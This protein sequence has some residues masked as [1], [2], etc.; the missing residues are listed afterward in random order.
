MDIKRSV[1]T[2]LSKVKDFISGKRGLLILAVLIN[3]AFGF[4]PAPLFDE[5]EGF[6]AEVAREMLER[7]EFVLLESNFEPRY[8]KPPLAFW[9]IAGSLYLFGNNEFAVRFPGICASVLLQYL[10]YA[11][12]RKRYGEKRA[13]TTGILVAGTLQFTLMSK[14]AIAD[15]FLYLFITAAILGLIDFAESGRRKYLYLFMVCNALAFLTK[16]PV[17]LFI[18]GTAVLTVLFYRREPAFLRRVLHPLPLLVFF[19]LVLPWFVLSY[20]KVGLLMIEEFFFKHNLGRFSQPM[21]GHDGSWL[22]YFIVFLVG[23]LPFSF[24][25]IYGLF[26]AVQTKTDLTER[27]CLVW[28]TAVFLLFSFSAT[29]LP[30]YLMPGFFPLVVVSSRYFSQKGQRVSGIFAAGLIFLLLTIP[31]TAQRVAPEIPDEYVRLLLAG[32]PAVFGPLYYGVQAVCLAGALYS[33]RKRNTV[34]VL[35]FLVSVNSALVAYS[36]VQQ[37]PVRELSRVVNTGIVMRNHYLPSFSF[38]R[39]QAYPVRE[40]VAGEYSVGKISDFRNYDYEIL[41]EKYGL[42]WVKIKGLMK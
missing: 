38:Y 35:F 1:K 2:M 24:S 14:S 30:H 34:F 26:R 36:W 25:H 41:Y 3:A 20:G 28:F 5:D 29:K 12:V 4:Y 13:V 37:G 32:F 15:P 11:F 9:L 6:T 18:S 7:K 16:G 31:L 42:V 17:A 39:Q 27:V 22:Y 10:L 21:E 40:P 19:A 33:I 23:F 8:D